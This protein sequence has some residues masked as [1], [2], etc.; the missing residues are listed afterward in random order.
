MQV[1]GF[2]IQVVSI[3]NED[4]EAWSNQLWE[5]GCDDSSPGV[6][7][8][9]PY[10]HFDREAA[11]LDAAIASAVKAVRSTGVEIDRVE[12]EDDDLAAITQQSGAAS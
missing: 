5:A 1:Y 9:K 7:S 4:L 8:G 12:L 10:V 2:T 3:P 11:S 6:F